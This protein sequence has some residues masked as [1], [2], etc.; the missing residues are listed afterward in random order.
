MD[1]FQIVQE[2]FDIADTDLASAK[3]LQSMHPIPIEII[4]YHCQQSAEKYLKGFLAWN[5]HEVIKTHDLVLLNQLCLSYDEGFKSIEEECLRL[6]DYA[7]NVRYPYPMDLN[8]TD[9]K[10][11]IKDAEKIKEFVLN[12]VRS[13]SPN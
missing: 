1:K 2:W 12:K 9:M 13:A 3:Y 5:E 7:V 11:A 8:E 10:L 4:C 6:T